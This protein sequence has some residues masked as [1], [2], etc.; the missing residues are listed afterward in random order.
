MN[1]QKFNIVV[2]GDKGC[3]K[4]TFIQKH[5]TSKFERKYLSTQDV[6]IYLLPFYTSEGII[7]FNIY[8]LPIIPFENNNNDFYY[9][10]ADLAIVF[11]DL[12]REITFTN[13]P[14]W[15][16]QFKRICP[17]SPIIIVGNK[18]D[19]KERK[20]SDREISDRIHTKTMLNAG[21]VYFDIS[22]KTNYNCDKP[23][24]AAAR[25]LMNDNDLKFKNEIEIISI[26]CG[27][28]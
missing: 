21:I 8:D 5:L 28:N 11:F 25:I 9:K 13:T 12:T 18:A 4:S 16:L 27:N 24:L 2:I 19:L 14:Q 22:V 6:N 26:M 3:G 17:K 10:N 15:I 23:L 7:E 1:T 20:V